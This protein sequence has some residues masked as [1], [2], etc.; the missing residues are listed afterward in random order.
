MSKTHWKKLIN[1]DY[2]GAYSLNEGQDMT[3]TL[4]N[5]KREMVTGN[6]GKKEECMV[7]YIKGNK[8]MILNR[9]NAKSIEKLYGPYIED[10]AGK[11]VTLYE[12]S[13]RVGGDTVACLRIRPT[14]TANGVKPKKK[15]DDTR[16]AEGMKSIQNGSFTAEAMREKFDL[17]PDQDAELSAF[18]ANGIPDYV[19][20]EDA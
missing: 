7:A 17:T 3:I 10:W 4:Q 11:Q 6:G 9:T 14:V 1:M 5:V 2:L 15:M 13:T 19:E 18:E 20:S 12:S 8:P 16:F